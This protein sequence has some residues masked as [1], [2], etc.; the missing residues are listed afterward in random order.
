MVF[1]TFPGEPV[2]YLS[3]DTI[4][5]G[6]EEARQLYPTEFLNSFNASSLPPHHLELKKFMPII[7]LRNLRPQEGLCNG[8]RLICKGFHSRVIEAEIVTGANAGETWIETPSGHNDAGHFFF[9]FGPT[10]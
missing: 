1:D 10:H 5:D 6:D 2:E 4:Q 8:T 3:A 9:I 7:L